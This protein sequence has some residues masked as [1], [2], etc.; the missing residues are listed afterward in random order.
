MVILCLS[1]SHK[2]ADL[3]ALESVNNKGKEHIF[4]SLRE[5]TLEGIVL[6]TCLR[7]EIYWDQ[8]GKKEQ[9]S[10]DEAKRIGSSILN[11]DAKKLDC[12]VF[13]GPKAIKHLFRIACGL[14]SAILGEHEILGQV[15]MTLKEG[16][17]KGT[18]GDMFETILHAAIHL[19]AKVRSETNIAKGNVSIGSVAVEIISEIFGSRFASIV[20]IGAGKVAGLLGKALTTLEIDDLIWMNRTYERSLMMTKR[21]N[22]RPLEFNR[23]NL[24]NVLLNADVMIFATGCPRQLLLKEVFFQ[25]DRQNPI[26]LID[27]GNPRNIAPEVADV[28]WVRLIDLDYINKWSSKGASLRAGEIPIVKQMIKQAMIALEEY[29]RCRWCEPAISE[30]YKFAEQ[31][32]LEQLKKSF[33]N[34]Q[35]DELSRKKVD[36]LTKAIVKQLLDTPIRSIRQRASSLP[37]EEIESLLSIFK[38]SDQ[39]VSNSQDLDEI[40]SNRYEICKIPDNNQYTNPDDF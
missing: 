39:K 38:S 9:L 7:T 8:K 40:A 30:I 35:Q 24:R 17:A 29:Q 15:K 3:K 23:D 18:V 6:Q 26:L 34:T 33:L 31:V 1:I 25:I 2:V 11:L 14:E 21:F 12:Q 28:S 22:A 27:L 4:A 5:R 32:R 16:I 37:F 20:I 19:G 10:D 13:V 36:I